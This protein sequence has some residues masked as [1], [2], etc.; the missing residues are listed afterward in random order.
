MAVRAVAAAQAEENGRKNKRKRKS[1]PG[2]A[3]WTAAER[4]LTLVVVV[5]GNEQVGLPSLVQ[6]TIFRAGSRR[7]WHGSFRSSLVWLASAD[8]N[9]SPLFCIYSVQKESS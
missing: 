3:R 6:E 4:I 1:E 7:T 9:P 8:S 5:D 2:C